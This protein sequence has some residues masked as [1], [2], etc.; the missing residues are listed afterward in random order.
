MQPDYPAETAVVGHDAGA[1]NILIAG[2]LE[3][4]RKEWRAFMRGPAE[5]GAE[6][7]VSGTGWATDIEHEARRLARGR[8]VQSVAI[9]DHWVN[10]EA[11]FIRKGETVWPDEFW[12]TDEYALEIAKRT[13]PGGIVRRVPN[14][15]VE[16]LLHDIALTDVVVDAPELLYVLEPIRKGWGSGDTPGEF[17]ALDYFVSH[18]P[19]LGLPS[20][21]IIRLRPHP[22]DADGKYD[23]WIARHPDLNLQLDD[24]LTITDSLGRSAWVAGCESFALVLALMAGRKVYCT[25]PPWAP[26]CR[27]PQKGI[28][29]L[30]DLQKLNNYA[31]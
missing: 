31:K 17:Q 25:L 9:I 13:F 8:G 11:R 10:Y 21:T 26:G 22:S 23:E 18:L 16:T 29:S 6:L 1:A 20:A 24:S 30:R 15:Y 5:N 12:V 3:T 2:L 27:L 19:R 28:V 14:R 4:G 7:L